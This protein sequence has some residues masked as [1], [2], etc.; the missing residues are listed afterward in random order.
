MKQLSAIKESAV[1][2]FPF[3]FFL[4]L[5]A[6]HHGCDQGEQSGQAVARVNS[7]VLTMEQIKAQSDPGR[8][9]SETDI[10][11]YVNRWIT[12]ELLYQEARQRGMD[13]SES[14]KEKVDEA[15]KQ[16][17]IAELLEQEVYAAAER[18]IQNSEV[19]AYY[20][21]HSTE[22]LLKD[23]LVRLSLII[24][25]TNSSATRFRASALGT[26]GWDESVN[27]FRLDASNG[28]VSY[29]DSLFFTQSSLYPPDLWKVATVL[30]MFEVSFPVN[31]SIGF[32]VMRSLGQFKKGTVAPIHYIQNDIRHRLAMERRQ[33]R[34]QEFIQKLRNK[35]TVQYMYTTADTTA[36]EGM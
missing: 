3:F 29:S 8:P 4:L 1:R 31:T 17:A 23:D 28:V 11:Q 32:V 26:T 22:Y 24:L 20:Q 12:G 15:R 36:Q 19:A 34:Y 35:H 16:L 30:G 13:E 2:R 9:L 21:A 25:N 6:T 7:T 33:Q 10:R 18:S 5:A 14:I 27:R